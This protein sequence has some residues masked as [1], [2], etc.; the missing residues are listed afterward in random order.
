VWLVTARRISEE[1]FKFGFTHFF[2]KP[3]M[4]SVDAAY[5]AYFDAATA[6]KDGSRLLSI[7]MAARQPPSMALLDEFG[8]CDVDCVVVG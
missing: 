7:L 2:A 6:Q 4:P 5:A 1:L 8:L 3:P